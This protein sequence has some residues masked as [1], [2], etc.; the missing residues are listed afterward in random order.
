MSN[1]DLFQPKNHI[2]HININLIFFGSFLLFYCK[3]PIYKWLSSYILCI[4]G[5]LINGQKVV[6][7]ITGIKP[8]FDV[9]VPE[10]M[11]LSMFKTKLVKILSNILN[12]T[13]K[14]GIETISAYPLKGYDTGKKPYIRVRT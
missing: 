7:N 6:V 4:A 14:F 1:L 8:F 11:P 9:V 2:W 10:E 13:S 5:T 3:G 12:S